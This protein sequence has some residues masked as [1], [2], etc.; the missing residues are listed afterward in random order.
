MCITLNPHNN[1]QGQL[2]LL[3][4]I[5]KQKYQDLNP[6]KL[7]LEPPL[8][9]TYIKLSLFNTKEFPYSEIMSILTFNT[10]MYFIRNG[11]DRRY[12]VCVCLFKKS[13]SCKVKTKQLNDST[14]PQDCFVF[15]CFFSKFFCWFVISKSE[16]HWSEKWN[17]YNFECSLE[18]C[19]LIYFLMHLILSILTCLAPDHKSY[20][21]PLDRYLL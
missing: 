13:L 8:L 10:K 16:N 15:C 14:S 7:T 4:L 12:K 3:L 17:S 18:V 21:H 2:L 1:L 11:G 6:G 19:H 5:S 20:F 9:A